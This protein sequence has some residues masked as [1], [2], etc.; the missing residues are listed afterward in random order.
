MPSRQSHGP[1][2]HKKPRISSRTAKRPSLARRTLKTKETDKNSDSKGKAEGDH[3]RKRPR[4]GQRNRDDDSDSA[5]S[6]AELESDGEGHEWRMGEVA[7]DDDSEIDSDAAFGPSDDERFQAFSFGKTSARSAGKKRKRAEPE[8]ETGLD[9]EVQLDEAESGKSGDDASEDSDYADGGGDV[10]DLVNMLDESV[11]LDPG[12]PQAMGE[13]SEGESIASPQGPKAIT[14]EDLGS[15]DDDSS[16]E[17]DDG[18][19]LEDLLARDSKLSRL[20]SII[21]GKQRI[22]EARPAQT[23]VRDINETRDPSDYGLIS[24]KKLELEDLMSAVSDPQMK[25]S[26]KLL[27][28][29]R[30]P[31][32]GQG[33][34]GKLEA[35]LPKRQQ[36]KLDR[37]AAY[38]KTK[39]S[40]NRWVD[41]VKHNRRAEQL[42]FPLPG[43]EDAKQAPKRF[44]ISQTRGNLNDLERAIQQAL[45][46]SGPGM[47]GD[48]AG[49][50]EIREFEEMQMNKVPFEEVQA[51]R[52]Q[53][54]M[55]RDLLFREEVRAKRIK[56]IKSKSYRRVHRKERQRLAQNEKDSLR[57]AGLIDPEE[58]AEEQ[59]RIRAAE[60]M[61]LRHNE[62]RWAKQAKADGRLGWDDDA[63]D[64]VE[65]MALRDE[66][67]RRR[68]AGKAVHGSDVVSESEESDSDDPFDEQAATR[69]IREELKRSD[70]I[71]TDPT[72]SGVFSMKFMQQA[73]A[74]KRRENDEAL[75]QLE[76]DFADGSVDEESEDEIAGR[77]TM[78]SKSQ[79]LAEQSV[80]REE[81]RQEFEEADASASEDGEDVRV[82]VDQ[83]VRHDSRAPN[84]SARKTT[85]SDG[86]TLASDKAKLLVHT[87]ANPWLNIKKGAQDESEGGTSVAEQDAD[88]QVSIGNQNVAPRQPSP[89]STSETPKLAE[90]LPRLGSSLI[91]AEPKDPYNWDLESSS[92]SEPDEER[93]GGSLL[94]SQAALLSRA[95]AGDDTTTASFAKEKASLADAEDDQIISN[96]LPGW[97]S[98]INP[99]MSIEKQMAKKGKNKPHGRDTVIK[100]VAA[101]AR[102]DAGLDK[103]IISEKNSRANRKY[104]ADRLPHPYEST[105]Q[106]EG[107]MRIP[108]G[109]EWSTAQQFR[110]A[111]RPKIV[112]PRGRV[113][114][115]LQRPMM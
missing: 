17:G 55:A 14:L 102:K 98:W 72:R 26:L 76:R 21:E 34:L 97:G 84:G 13:V 61:G 78:V 101:N 66:Q 86:K 53:L 63:R 107:Q 109:R 83:G 47:G 58:E 113:L 39:E 51:R 96:E 54:R 93:A 40:L 92:G 115:P 24:S 70:E 71:T 114:Q 32:K 104:M 16:S 2:Q 49:E 48:K 56:K 89:S 28:T 88:I 4:F 43:Q 110:D 31:Q 38:E 45:G 74:A 46:N 27:E 65:Q 108:I 18:A 30:K 7:S 11:E 85:E 100:G 20:S 37:I 8:G 10:M 94:P 44:E 22:E 50:N 41:T 67:L 80:R 5:E 1:A 60:R 111:T 90:R 64:G 103:V 3:P 25:K 77:R 15:E 79:V 112:V 95:F 106:Y 29:H 57:E 82:I 42:V 19:D 105:A 87:T 6:A 69:A 59:Q 23:F 68:I 91:V 12:V 36:D 52:A 35:P 73:E 9:G 33:N 99:G 75:Q 81:A 62:S